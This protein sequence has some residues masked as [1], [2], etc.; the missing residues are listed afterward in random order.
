M[1]YVVD[2]SSNRIQWYPGHMA[3]AKRQLAE[4]LSMVDAVIEI[5]DARLPLSSR[6][7]DIG[8][9]FGSKPCL[10]LLNKSSLADDKREKYF[11][12]LL[13]SDGRRVIAVD[14]KAYRNI[15]L[16]TP[17]LRELLTDKLES[18][19]AKGM[20]RPLRVMVAGI[21][22]VGKSTFINTYTK[23]KKAKAEDRPGVT[24]ESRWISSPYGIE[25][26][27][28]PGLLWHKFDDPAVGIK[29]ACTGAIK[30]E[31]LDLY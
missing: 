27:D 16:V 30:D 4:S 5:L 24:R 29:L 26:L 3:K 1:I 15:S 13:R 23:T 10:T 22:N 11:I 12:D 14:C 25:M 7:P 20:T 21:T 17:A 8:T 18:D 9:L 31:I 6:N 28:T 19:A 2:I